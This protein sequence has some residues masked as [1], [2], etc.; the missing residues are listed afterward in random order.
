MVSNCK[1]APSSASHEPS[2]HRPVQELLNAHASSKAQQQDPFSAAV[3]A[4]SRDRRRQK[5]YAQNFAPQIAAKQLQVRSRPMSATA[6]NLGV[7]QRGFLRPLSASSSGS[8]ILLPRSQQQR[9]NE[10]LE[11]S[12]SSSDHSKELKITS[13]QLMCHDINT[14][15]Q[16]EPVKPPT[17]AGWRRPSRPAS[18]ANR[19]ERQCMHPVCRQR[20]CS[21]HP[22]AQS[23]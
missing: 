12:R 14:K 13:L 20:P 23:P 21:A 22:R 10:R 19:A 4:E 15:W 9:A 7:L 3:E 8:S 5:I 17:V 1:M 2:I 11:W 18:A 6:T 16:I